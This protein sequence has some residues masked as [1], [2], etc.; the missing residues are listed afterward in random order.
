MRSCLLII[1]FCAAL[2]SFG[3]ARAQ[4]GFINSLLLYSTENGRPAIADTTASYTIQ[5]IF[6]SGAKR[7][8]RSTILRELPFQSNDSYPLAEIIVKTEETKRQLMNTGLFRNVIVCLRRLEDKNVS[9]TI[10][11]EEKWYFFPQPFLRVANG[12]FSQWNER[13]RKLSDLNYGIK[14]TQY[15]FS[16]RADKLHLHLTNG[17]TKKIALQYQ[18]FYFDKELK[19]SGSIS[20]AHGKNREL[21][22]ATENN[23]LL[24]VKNPDG[25]LFEFFQSSVDVTYRPAIKTRHTF[26]IGYQYNRIGD[27]VRKLNANFSFSKNTYS[28]PYIGY[29]ISFI[30]YDFNPYP[31]KGRA[32]EISISKTG[33]SR[34]I[35]LWQ[36]SLK[37][38]KYWEVSKNAF[39]SVKA[40]GLLKLPFKQ[41]YITQQFLGYGDDFLQ[42]YENYIVDGVAGGYIKETIAYNFMAS[43]IPLPKTKWFKSLHSIPFKLYVKAFAN[44]GYVFNPNKTLVNDLNNKMLYSTGLGLDIV[45]FTD[46][47]FKIEWSFNQLGQNALYLHQ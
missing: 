15:N 4:E 47:I 25:Y 41:P 17:Y 26:S 11:V 9:V 14:F 23:R 34:S 3:D 22:Y 24:P 16:G 8:R 12:T 40:A 32:G 31:T 37:G 21:N 6:I 2:L 18:G 43:Q 1:G 30:D 28:Y 38:T 36:L 20:I 27:T 7:T 45:A 10:E 29:A 33:I 5:E 39:F 19:W 13:G 44:T 42:G 35:N 46:L